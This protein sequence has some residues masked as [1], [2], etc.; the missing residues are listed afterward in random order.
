MKPGTPIRAAADVEQLW[1]EMM[2][3]GGFGIRTLWI[4]FLDETGC[5]SD[6]IVPIEDIPLHPDALLLRNLAHIVADVGM[7]SVLLLVSRPGSRAMT[8]D[9][10]AWA[11]ELGAAMGAELC[12]W[13]IHLATGDHIQVF[14]ADDLIPSA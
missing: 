1:E 10:R 6:V 7:Q 8:D 14:A 11:R 4:V 2:G 13:P 9:D 5:T 3:P 12:R